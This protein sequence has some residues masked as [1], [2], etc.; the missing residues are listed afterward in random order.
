VKRP[1]MYARAQMRAWLIGANERADFSAEV[2][3][4]VESG[5][6]R[7]VGVRARD[8]PAHAHLRKEKQKE[9]ERERERDKDGTREEREEGEGGND[10]EASESEGIWKGQKPLGISRRDARTVHGIFRH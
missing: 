1:P 8:I 6:T 3:R 9:R 5:D 4:A 10:K 7:S 2:S